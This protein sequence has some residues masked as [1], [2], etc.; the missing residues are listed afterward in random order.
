M[1]KRLISDRAH[2]L[3]KKATTLIVADCVAHNGM[4]PGRVQTY[5]E[6]AVQEGMN[7]ARSGAFDETRDIADKLIDEEIS[8]GRPAGQEAALEIRTR[9]RKVM[10]LDDRRAIPAAARKGA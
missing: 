9:I 7:E 3:A 6:V 1:G 4:M 2:E 5:I 8:A 10:E